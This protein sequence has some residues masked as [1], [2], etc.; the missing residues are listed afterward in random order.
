MN[1]Q[2]ISATASLLRG[3]RAS[4][5]PVLTVRLQ[6]PLPCGCR[7]RAAVIGVVVGGGQ[8]QRR[9]YCE[10]HDEISGNPISSRSLPPH[11]P[12]VDMPVHDD[13]A[14]PYCERCAAPH[15]EL[16]HWAPRHAFDDADNWPT[17]WLCRACHRRWHATVISTVEL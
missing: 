6:D 10:T 15:A 16:H 7:F 14:G 17:G 2:P 3:W 12:G 1:K 8:I 11:T 13:N 4:E 9:Y 5:R